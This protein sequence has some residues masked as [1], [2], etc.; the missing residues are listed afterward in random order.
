M[1]SRSQLAESM[2]SD[3][4]HPACSKT[5]SFAGKLPKAQAM[6]APRNSQMASNCQTWAIFP[7]KHL[8]PN[9]PKKTKARAVESPWSHGQKNLQNLPPPHHWS[10]A[11][12]WSY[13]RATDWTQMT[14]LGAGCLR[15]AAC[16]G[17]WKKME[18]GPQRGWNP[19]K[20]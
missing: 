18:K 1:E 19:E 6:S 13:G 5:Q 4:T 12:L 2:P 9:N 17:C 10:Y 14:S 3:D 11:H 16:Q 8:Q 15:C 20:Q 7:S